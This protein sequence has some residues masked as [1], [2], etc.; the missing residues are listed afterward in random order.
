M[1]PNQSLTA[2]SNTVTTTVLPI[3]RFEITPNGSDTTNAGGVTP[4]N[5]NGTVGENV[6]FTY[7]LENQGNTDTNV[8]NLSVTQSLT[9][10]FDFGA[11]TIY[12]DGGDGIFGTADDTIVK[13][14]GATTGPV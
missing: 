14:A 2:T 10:Q 6:V 3:Y 13:A 4:N 9:D 11:A 12:L 7:N 1:L 5:L 8:I